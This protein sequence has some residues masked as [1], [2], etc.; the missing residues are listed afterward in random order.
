MALEEKPEVMLVDIGLPDMSGY[1]VAREI[2]KEG[3]DCNLIAHS[4]YSHDTARR[5][6]TEAGFDHHL[7]K[8]LDLKKFQE[9]VAAARP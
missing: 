4:G 5:K 7:A 1:D 6:S 8:P 3:L 2:R 9:I